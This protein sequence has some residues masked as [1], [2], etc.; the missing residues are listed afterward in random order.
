AFLVG[1]GGGVATVVEIGDGRYRPAVAGEGGALAIIVACRDMPA[2]GQPDDIY[3]LVAW[4]PDKR[5]I[6]LRHGIATLIRGAAVHE[7]LI[8]VGGSQPLHVFTDLRAWASAVAWERRE[9]GIFI[10]DW[11]AARTE[12]GFLVG[13][14]PFI[15]DDVH[16]GRRLR[17]ALRPKSS[18]QPEIFV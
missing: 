7:S 1:H 6:L 10:I 3:D 4:L 18:T 9:P 5:R 13:T 16:T 12:L 11:S 2:P 15:V 17:D 14:T 8:V